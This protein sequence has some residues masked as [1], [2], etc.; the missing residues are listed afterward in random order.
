M[1]DFLREKQKEIKGTKARRSLAP[2]F[3]TCEPVIAE[4]C[5]LIERRGLKGTIILERIENGLMRIA[6]EIED[7]LCRS[8]ETDVALREHPDAP[9][10]SCLVRM[11]E[12]YP[13]SRVFTLDSDFRF[14]RC[15]GRQVIPTI[16]PER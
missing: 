6:I 16:F 3:L 14:Y 11:S 2:P 15:N 13:G 5:F 8:G 7:H 4:A 10:D 12:V 9:A 1:C